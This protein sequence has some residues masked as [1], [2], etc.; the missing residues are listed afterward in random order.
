LRQGLDHEARHRRLS[1]R[2]LASF[3]ERRAECALG[4]FFGQA[5]IYGNL[6]DTIQI[7]VE[8]SFFVNQE[9]ASGV[10][11]G[12]GADVYTATE[13]VTDQRDTQQSQKGATNC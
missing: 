7:E 4:I 12:R 6:V 10:Q 13:H 8:A 1:A 9:T 2:Q 5:G 3:P 11:H